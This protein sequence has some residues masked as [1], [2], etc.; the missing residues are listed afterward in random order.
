MSPPD[1]LLIQGMFPFNADTVHS[2]NDTY[3]LSIAAALEELVN[4]DR[5]LLYDSL[6]RISTPSEEGLVL[7][8]PG[9]ELKHAKANDLAVELAFRTYSF[10]LRFPA[11]LPVN[12]PMP[13]DNYLQFFY[14]CKLLHRQILPFIHER[15]ASYGNTTTTPPT[16]VSE[17]HQNKK[18]KKRAII[19]FSFP[20][21]PKEFHAGH[22][23][24][25]ILGALIANLYESR[26]WDVVRLNYLGDSGKR[27][28][29][30]WW[31]QPLKHLLNVY[32]KINADFKPEEPES[33]KARDEGR[34]TAE[35]QSR[36]L[37]DAEALALWK[38]FRDISIERYVDIYARLG[39]HF[40]GY[41]GESQVNPATVAEVEAILK[42]KGVYEEDQGLWLIDFAK[43]GAKHF[44]T[45]IVRGRTG[46]TTYLLR[47]VASILCRARQ[48][49]FDEMLYIVSSEEDAYFQ[50]VFNTVDLLNHPDHPTLATKCKH[51]NFGK[52]MGMS[53][54]LS[55]VELL[56]DILDRCAGAMHDV[57]R[58]NAAKYAQHGPG[59]VAQAHQQLPPFDMARMTSSKGDTE[60]YLQYCHARLSSVLRNARGGAGGVDITQA[61]AGSDMIVMEELDYSYLEDEHSAALFR[62]TA[63]YPDPSTV[64]TYLFRLAHQL[65]SSYDV[66]QVVGA[67]RKA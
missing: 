39:I 32:V 11:L 40:H 4:C 3:C 53:T 26:G 44:G 19:E 48:Y 1:I 67:P 59:H 46:T 29:R 33:K 43:H 42:A 7:V 27:F 56:S 30:W 21:I 12:P 14:S 10:C 51:V 9:L 52:V 8:L 31:A 15:K 18:K 50:R 5:L 36:G 34:D 17:H 41:A 64:L 47:D 13:Q 28:G 55:K 22:L 6:Q 37:G 23:R 20:S 49:S 16:L 57:M 45:A 58:V 65:S 25:T 2:P 62:T 66:L 35:I 24:S 60:P 63:Q 54:R 61:A 38:R